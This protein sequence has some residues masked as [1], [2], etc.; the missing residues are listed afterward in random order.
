MSVITWHEHFQGV[1]FTLAGAGVGLRT[2][3]AHGIYAVLPLT[4]RDGS[5][6][7]FPCISFQLASVAEDVAG[8]GLVRSF[9]MTA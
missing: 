1:Q 7:S 4:S 2:Q 9:S 5:G 8:G 6:G 3:S